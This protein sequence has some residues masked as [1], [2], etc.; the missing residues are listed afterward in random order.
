MILHATRNGLQYPVLDLDTQ[1]VPLP[2]THAY[3]D[4]NIRAQ[5]I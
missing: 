4:I 2:S 3:D 5:R 1:H